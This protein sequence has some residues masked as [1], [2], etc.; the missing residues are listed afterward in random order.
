[1][2]FAKRNWRVPKGHWKPLQ[3]TA[4]G[5]I[6]LPALQRPSGINML[7]QPASE[8]ADSSRADSAD[9]MCQGQPRLASQSSDTA[10]QDDASSTTSESQRDGATDKVTSTSSDASE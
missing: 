6:R 1:M 2:D 9:E 7:D 3:F 8:S 4:S 5:H 10:S